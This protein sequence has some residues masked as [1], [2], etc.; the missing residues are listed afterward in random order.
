M[1]SILIA[2]L[3]LGLIIFVHEFGHF[4]FAKIFKVPVRE[5]SLGM[6][7]RLFSFIIGKTRYSLKLFPIGGSCALIGEDP[8]GSGDMTEIDGVI[9]REKNTID[10]EGVVYDLDY[11]KKNNYGMIHPIKKLLICF[12]GPLFNFILAFILAVILVSFTGIDLPNIHSISEKS[13]AKEAYPIALE[14]GDTIISIQIPTDGVKKVG[15]TRDITLFMA[16]NEDEIKKYSLPLKIEF[17]RNGI[18]YETALVPKYDEDS[19]RCLIGIALESQKKIDNFLDNIKYGFREFYF[20]IDSTIIS[21]RMLIKGKMPLSAVSGPVGTVAV[22]GSSIKEART[23]NLFST[24][25]TIMTLTILI[26]ANLGVMNLLPIPALDGGRM[27]FA[28][29]ELVIGRKI[30]PK[31]ET[32][33][34]VFTMILLL[35]FMAWVFGLDIIKLVSN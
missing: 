13:A 10:F 27:I 30:N 25:L 5:F 2:I 18:K 17:V 23:V 31:I 24:I 22:M 9:D 33:L 20:Y 3:V 29:V 26:S 32:F 7:Q 19:D 4:V 11:V 8:A 14:T 21:L 35:L 6:G 15:L 12:A 16:L 28:I 1:T 34:N